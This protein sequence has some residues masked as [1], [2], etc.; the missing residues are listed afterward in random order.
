MDAS[1]FLSD[2]LLLQ[3]ESERWLPVLH[4]DILYQAQVYLGLFGEMTSSYAILM[5]AIVYSGV[6]TPTG[7]RVLAA[8]LLIPVLPSPFFTLSTGDPHFA[9]ELML[10]WVGPYYLLTCLLLLHTLYWED[11]PVLRQKHMATACIVIPPVIAYLC[12]HFIPRIH[13]EHFHG[14]HYIPLFV[15]ICFLLFFVLSTR[16]RGFVAP[17]RLDKHCLSDKKMFDHTWQT[18]ASGTSLLHHAIK[19]RVIILNMLVERMSEEVNQQQTRSLTDDI[20]LLR[21]ETKQM[22]QLLFR[23]QKK[24]D[25]VEISPT[26]NS[27]SQ[28]MEQTL[29]AHRH[30]LDGKEVVWKMDVKE[31]PLLC[32]DAAHLQEAFSNL[33]M[34]A[35]ESMEAGCGVLDIRIFATK[36]KAVITICDNGCGIPKEHLPLIF[37]PYYSSKRGGGHIGLGLSYCQLVVEKHN[38][39]I[40]VQSEPGKGSA[41]TIVLPLRQKLPAPAL[42]QKWGLTHE[43]H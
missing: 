23:L 11:N 4:L 28:I 5:F 6:A 33:I 12:L 38:G 27:I 8:L 10:A 43:L 16:Y 20:E 14:Y 30:L 42:D 26:L 35:V 13:D 25:Q 36:R 31:V 39:S 34:N 22:L 29:R 2:Q 18:V 19:N 3:M 15:G 32:C 7:Q 1:H 40:S 37:K 41:F 17:F 21:T 9:E 24:L